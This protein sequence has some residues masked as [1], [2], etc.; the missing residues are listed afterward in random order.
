MINIL[1]YQLIMYGALN[2][3]KRCMLLALKFQGQVI[4]SQ[5]RALRSTK[6][7]RSTYSSFDSLKMYQSNHTVYESRKF[8]ESIIL[9]SLLVSNKIIG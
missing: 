5:N 7:F 8:N 2:I 9:I 6:E 1:Y 3:F 4:V